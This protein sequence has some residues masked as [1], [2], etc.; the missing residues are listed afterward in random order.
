M[1]QIET[2][3]PFLL[4]T[5]DSDFALGA[6]LE[7]QRGDKWVPVAFYNWK[8]ARGKKN[9]T[10]REKVTY[11]IVTA[12]RKWAGWIGFQPV[13]VKTDHRSLENW[14]TEHIDTPSGT[15]LPASLITGP[16][17]QLHTRQRIV[18]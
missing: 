16:P 12:L 7:Q 11:A 4:Q 5:D 2:D 17:C 1:F 18:Q 14:V 9:W 10:A 3:Q 6:V 13:V 15:T 8:L